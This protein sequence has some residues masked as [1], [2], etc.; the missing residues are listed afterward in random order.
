MAISFAL[1]ALGLQV[2][3]TSADDLA[4]GPESSYDMKIVMGIACFSIFVFGALT[5]V[6]FRFADKLQSASLYKD[7]LCSLI[8][9]VLA[10]SLFVNTMIIRN[11]PSLW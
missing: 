6:K 9:T 4:K 1:V 10:M 8:G 5:F 7:G 11:N 2:M 3:I